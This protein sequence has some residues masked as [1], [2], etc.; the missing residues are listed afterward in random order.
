MIKNEVDQTIEDAINSLVALDF[1]KSAEHLQSIAVSF[2]QCGMT[3][4]SFINIKSYIIESARQKGDT[5]NLEDQ[6][7]LAEK[8]LTQKRKDHG[9]QTH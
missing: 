5:D 1:N 6:L 3:L 9:K 7:T 4:N 2:A 8:T